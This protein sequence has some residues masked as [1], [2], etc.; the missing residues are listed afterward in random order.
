MLIL[1]FLLMVLN[2]TVDKEKF[3]FAYR[4]M[5]GG[6]PINILDGLVA[7]AGVAVLFRLSRRNYPGEKTHQGLKW[8]IG[9]LFLACL[10]GAGGG[11]LHGI[12]LREIADMTRNVATLGI[13]LVIGYY[14]TST[15]RQS[16]WAAIIILFSSAMSALFVILFLRD[17]IDSLK[18]VSTSFNDLRT[19]SRGGDAGIVGMSFV[20]FAAVA[21]IR[22]FPKIISGLMLALCAAGSFAMPHRSMWATAFAT[23]LFS[24]LFLP[25]VRI[26][27]KLGATALVSVL[28]VSVVMTGVIAY[29]RLTGRDFQD[30]LAVR[31]RS[32]L[33]GVEETRDNKAWDTRLP[34]LFTELK[35]WS[36]NPLMG[37]GFG[38]QGIR[39]RQAGGA[40]GGGYRHNVWTSSLAE[41]GLPLFLGYLLPCVL[42]VMVGRRLV[43]NQMD[44]GTVML[45]AIAALHGFM[46]FVLASTTMSINLQRPA[47]PLGLICGLL[48]RTRDMQL[49]ITRSYAGY[50]D[51]G[52]GDLLPVEEG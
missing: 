34:G 32:M 4:I 8:A 41:G 21:G 50:I 22:F 37:G 15:M 42:C 46:S 18:S 1:F 33:P 36:E 45:G 5:I 24:C 39:E 40:I 23:L 7:V 13:C 16:R 48:L 12:E 9:M 35:I 20:T 44:R 29:A 38:I 27:R 3:L 14:T 49:A 43:A 10:T 51:A 2:Y 28:L 26:G 17:S 47:I 25:R 31:F 11:V 6:L 52:D 19:S 30:Y